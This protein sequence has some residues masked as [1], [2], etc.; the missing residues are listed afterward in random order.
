MTTAPAALTAPP[1][2]RRAAPVPLPLTPAAAGSSA[3]AGAMRAV[4]VSVRAA[5]S[6]GAEPAPRPAVGRIT[7]TAHTTRT[8][9]EIHP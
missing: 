5:S 4:P 3:P 2:A 6:T 9:E 7:R 1:G 8:A